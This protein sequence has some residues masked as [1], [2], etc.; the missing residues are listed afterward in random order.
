MGRRKT[1]SDAAV[2]EALLAMLGTVGPE[3]LSF[4][5]ASK[6]SGLGAATLVQRFGSREAMVEAVL[7]HA[8]D[9]LDRATAAADAQ[10]PSTP[11]GAIA[12]LVEL[13]PEA[14]ASD[15]LADGLL[16]LREDFRNPVLRARGL[17][18]GQTLARALGCRLA[19]RPGDA[20]RLGWQMARL[21][22]GTLIWWGF[23]REGSLREHVETALRA[24]GP[25]G[26][27]A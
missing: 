5:V 26:E 2:L 12:L 23:T 21:W 19:T 27:G 3:G 16:L 25:S 1:I 11:A 7:L 20:E 15:G 13:T 24:G 4:A 17:A 18:W 10:A 6:A 14:T 8:W 22:Q 9:A